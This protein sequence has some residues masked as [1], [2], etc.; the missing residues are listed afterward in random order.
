MERRE[1]MKVGGLVLA[2][3]ACAYSLPLFVVTKKTLASS[4]EETPATGVSYGMVIDVTKCDADCTECTKACRKENNVAFHDDK[5]WDIHLIRKVKVQRRKSKELS[6]P[7][8][9][10]H[11]DNPPCAQAC[12]VAATYKR[13]EDGV[14]I[15]DHHRCI[16]CRYCMI[17]CPYNARF[18]NYKENKESH[19]WKN[20]N[21]DTTASS[22]GVPESCNFCSH[23]LREGQ[24]PACVEACKNKAMI[25]G[26]L[27]NSDSEIAKFIL[28]N[29][30]KGIREDFGTKPKVLYKGL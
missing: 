24:K 30:V 20:L 17:A 18:F 9:C 25:F 15:V 2:G 6:V 12:P 27:N 13:P 29:H 5:R 19:D 7:L 26:D 3:T 8:L 4:E 28:N 23:R 1:F 14:V 16:G 22:H 10:N 11:C 21:K